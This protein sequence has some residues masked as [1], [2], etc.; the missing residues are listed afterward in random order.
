MMVLAGMGRWL[1]DASL[2]LLLARSQGG[3]H[4]RQQHNASAGHA[5]Q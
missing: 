4:A 3:A 2:T 5:Q 1:G